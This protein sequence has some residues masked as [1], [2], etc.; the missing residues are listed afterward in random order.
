MMVTRY[1]Q[2]KFVNAAV[3]IPS[4]RYCLIFREEVQLG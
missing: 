2:I 4:M 1:W 3:T